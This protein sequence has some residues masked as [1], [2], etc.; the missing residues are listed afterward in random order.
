MEDPQL[1]EDETL[2]RARQIVAALGEIPLGHYYSPFPSASDVD[3]AS[4]TMGSPPAELRGVDLDPRGQLELLEVLAPLVHESPLPF[5][6]HPGSRFSHDN[7]YFSHGDADT[8]QAMIRHLRPRR[9]VEVGSGFSSALALDT[10]DR[11]FDGAIDCVFIE[12]DPERLLDLLHP[13]DLERITIMRQ[14]VQDASRSVFESLEENDILFIDSS[15]VVKAGSDVNYEVF[16]ILPRL[17]PGVHVQFHDIHYPFDYTRE[18]IA[19]GRAWSESY[20]LRAFLQYNEAFEIRLFCDYLRRFHPE[21]VQ[22]AIPA[23]M[24]CPPGSLWLRRSS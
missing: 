13:G 3:R 24:A 11:F 2:E 21:P 22:R 5:H 7:P 15:H 17:R 23:L 12:P 18:W 6:P 1:Q 19:E 8:L 20:L 4:R 10:N 16:E 14:L 9:F